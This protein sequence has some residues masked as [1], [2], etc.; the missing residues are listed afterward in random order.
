[1]ILDLKNKRIIILLFFYNFYLIFQPHY[2][3]TAYSIKLCIH[4]LFAGYFWNF[5]ITFFSLS[6]LD[7]YSY[8]SLFSNFGLLFM[9]TIFLTFPFLIF[10]T[11]P[12]AFISFFLSI[13]V[14]LLLFFSYN[15]LLNLG[16]FKIMPSLCLLVC[17][18]FY[19]KNEFYSHFCFSFFLTIPMV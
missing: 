1:M 11:I 19:I 13:F 18:F 5:V 2:F 8:F 9:S 12:K 3:S 14:P 16:I 17:V 4:S 15:S 10:L 7:I 6:F